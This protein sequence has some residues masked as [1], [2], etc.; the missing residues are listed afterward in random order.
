MVWLG[1]G[2]HRVLVAAERGERCEVWDAGTR[3]KGKEQ[4]ERRKR[5]LVPGA[6]INASNINPGWDT[7]R[8]LAPPLQGNY[9]LALE[10]LS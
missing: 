2:S 5:A 8:P 9:V 6:S 7:F 3:A 4:M 10:H 1:G